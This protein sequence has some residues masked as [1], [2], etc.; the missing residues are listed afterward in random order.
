MRG[1]PRWSVAEA[2]PGRAIL[3]YRHAADAWP[4]SYR[5]R[6]IVTLSADRLTLRIELTN[7]GG[8]GV[9]L[10]PGSGTGLVGLTERV[11]LAGGTLD[12][13]RAAGGGFRLHASLPWPHD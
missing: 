5:S 3:D 11:Q 8:N 6:Q 12:H 13:G 4:F 1:K 10:A 7:A 9:P 2:K